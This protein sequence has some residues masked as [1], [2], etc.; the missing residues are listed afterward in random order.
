MRVAQTAIQYLP[1]QP[2]ASFNLEGVKRQ[3]LGDDQI[4]RND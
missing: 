2:P 3:V 1:M 4:T